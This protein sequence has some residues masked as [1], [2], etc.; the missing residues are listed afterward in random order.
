M[1]INL[2][3]LQKKFKGLKGLNLK[4][5]LSKMKE[6]TLYVVIMFFKQQKIKDF[7]GKALLERK[8]VGIDSLICAARNCSNEFKEEAWERLLKEDL[9]EA[10]L[11]HIIREIPY[12]R[13]KA[14]EK[15]S[16]RYPKKKKKGY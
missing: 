2:K 5:H 16:E 10:N 9:S 15:L 6:K 3:K 1:I 7:A 14:K 13:E 4:K 12:L 11:L 8:S